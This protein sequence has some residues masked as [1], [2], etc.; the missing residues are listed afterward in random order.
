[1]AEKKLVVHLVQ[2]SEAT[3]LVHSVVVLPRED[4]V[5]FADELAW[6]Q[7]A[8]YSAQLDPTHA[9]TVFAGQRALRVDARG[10]TIEFLPRVPVAQVGYVGLRMALHPGTAAG[11]FRPSLGLVVNGE[12]ARPLSLIDQIDLELNQWQTVE[13]ALDELA[14]DGPIESLRLIGSLRGTFYLDEIRLVAAQ[15]SGGVTA[16]RE[17]ENRI[18]AP[19]EFAIDPN[20]PNPF[21]SSTTIRYRIAEPAR[22]RLEIFDVQ[23]QKVKTLANGDVG[24]GVLPS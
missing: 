10:F 8:L 4:Q 11:G 18:A 13:I 6:K 16:V 7:G 19:R 14:L 15:Y 5:L 9:D 12:T 17:E 1:M 21:N 3:K 24:P 2:G 22:V 23:G 20:Y